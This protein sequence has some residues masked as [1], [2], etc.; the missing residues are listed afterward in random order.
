MSQKYFTCSLE[1]AQEAHTK[2]WTMQHSV[3]WKP[4]Q[5]GISGDDVVST[6]AGD[7]FG[8]ALLW[9]VLRHD[10]EG[11]FEESD[12]PIRTG[13]EDAFRM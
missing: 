1:T 6:W 3:G 9:L 13:L 5:L 10:Y 7:P 11:M 4:S 12:E 2:V 8:A